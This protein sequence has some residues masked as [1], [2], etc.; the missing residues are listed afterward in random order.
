MGRDCDSPAVHSAFN[1]AEGLVEFIAQ[2]RELSGGKPIGIKMC[3]GRFDEVASI[4]YAMRKLH[5][6]PDFITID[7]SEGGTGAGRFPPSY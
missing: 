5:S 4:I 3:V 7:G 6:T 2:L 1:D